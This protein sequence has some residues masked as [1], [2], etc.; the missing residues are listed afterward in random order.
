MASRLSRAEAVTVGDV[1]DGHTLL[2]IDCVDR[3]Y[4]ALS[5]PT[6]VAGGSGGQL[7]HR[8]RPAITSNLRTRPARVYAFPLN[9]S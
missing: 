8:A 1:L 2:Q 9:K 6:L 7:P 3:V 5:V 4:L